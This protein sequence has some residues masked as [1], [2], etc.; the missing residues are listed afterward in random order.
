LGTTTEDTGCLH[1]PK[2]N[3]LSKTRIT[4]KDLTG[5]KAK[6]KKANSP[7]GREISYWSIHL[8]KEAKSYY[9]SR[10]RGMRG[11]KGSTIRGRSSRSIL[12]VRGDKG[13]TALTSVEFPKE[14]MLLTA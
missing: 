8:K 14:S 10:K 7:G 2:G 9:D 5:E 3:S 13:I 1:I 12:K 11:K 4:K 6:E